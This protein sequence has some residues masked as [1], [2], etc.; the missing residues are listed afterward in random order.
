MY[1]KKMAVNDIYSE[2]MAQHLAGKLLTAISRTISFPLNPLYKSKAKKGY[3]KYAII[4]RTDGANA[5]GS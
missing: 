2:Q 5:I 4:S 1:G 3:K